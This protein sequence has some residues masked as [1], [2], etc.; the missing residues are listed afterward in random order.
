MRKIS[1]LIGLAL[2]C[3]FGNAQNP[4][5][6]VPDQYVTNPGGGNSTVLPLPVPELYCTGVPNIPDDPDSGYDGQLSDFS[7]N[8]QL[9][10]AGNILF[11]IVDGIIYD[12]NGY[13]I[14]RMSIYSGGPIAAGASETVIVPDPADCNRY[15]IIAARVQN[16]EKLAHVFLLDMSLPNRT[17][18]GDNCEYF[19]RLVELTCPNSNFPHINL[20]VSCVE[21]S[22]DPFDHS[23]GKNS[24]C[25]IAASKMQPGGH[26]FVFISN[27][28]G[29]FRFRID[30]TGFNYDNHF[31]SFGNGGMTQYSI[32][33][34]MELVELQGGGFRLAVPYKT[35]TLPFP[36]PNWENLFVVD[37][38]AN[39]DADPSTVIKFHMV[40][41]STPGG[42]DI[43][44]IIKGVEFSE[45]GDRIYV[46][47]TTNSTQPHQMEFYDFGTSPVELQPFSVDPNIDTRF[48]M[49]EL[50]K[51]DNMILANENGLY[52]LPNST[53]ANP[54][55]L[56]GLHMFNYA[57]SYE[58]NAGSTYRKMY[59][60]PDQ[61]DGMD[62]DAQ[63]TATVECCLNSS[64]FEADRFASHTDNW[65]GNQNPFFTS[66]IYIKEEFRVP[67]GTELTL[68][69]LSIHFA[70]GARLVIE[71]GSNGQQGGKLTLNN[72]VLTVDQRCT[73]DQMW[74]GV[75]VWGNTN[76]AQGSLNNSTQGR[77]IMNPSSRI[78]HAWIGALVS[79]RYAA[80]TSSPNGCPDDVNIYP[81]T[82]ED[83][84]N[85]GIVRAA[86]STFLNNQRGVWFRPYLASTGANNLSQFT[87]TT[88]RWDGPLKG[89]ASLQNQAQLYSVKGITFR[90]CNFQNTNPGAFA[91]TQLGTGILSLR[92]Q[93]YVLE[94]CN[95]ITQPCE[96]CPSGVPSTFDNLRFGIRTI[97]PGNMTFTV[98]DS[99]FNNC[100]YGMDV[101]L[102]KKGRILENQFNIR[103]ASYQ[104]AGVVLRYAPSFTVEENAFRGLGSSAGYLSY[105]VV[106]N[107]SG[108]ADNDIYLNS[109]IDLH[110]GGQSEYNN[111]VELTVAND[112]GNGVSMTGLNWTCNS[113]LDGIED[114]DL[115]V[116]NGRIDYFQ[117]HAIGHGSMNE[118]IRGSARNRFSLHGEPLS[119]EHDVVVS[120]S[121][122][123]EL[124]YVGLNTPFYF[125]DSYSSN[126]VL[127]LISS[128]NGVLA[129]ATPG[130]C[131]SNCQGDKKVLEAKRLQLQTNLSQLE[132]DW[133]DAGRAPVEEKLR[134][135]SQI[136]QTREQ[137]NLVDKQLLSE[138]LSSYESLADLE[139]ELSALDAQDL[140]T[141]LEAVFASDLSQGLP[142][143]E[144]DEVD[145]FLPIERTPARKNASNVL[146]DQAGF[147]VYPNPSNGR[148]AIEL[149]LDNP[150]GTDLQIIDLMGRT[151][152]QKSIS[153]ASN[154]IDLSD[155]SNGIYTLKLT[156]GKQLIGT[157]K[158]E[159]NR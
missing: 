16:Y 26:H 17:S 78:E 83:S 23:S 117:G 140:F 97:N 158:I 142:N 1:I 125:A 136:H 149:D 51:N 73:T 42:N 4:A 45:H 21:N 153:K 107:N 14:D 11:F 93:F 29:V 120:G 130:M 154:A 10:R 66:N 114:A 46:T 126:W 109:F 34:E 62:Y 134:I 48:S 47:H 112:P 155:L 56:N 95:V 118:A 60:L 124:Q 77:L 38:D 159:I 24:N 88:F 30:A 152:F 141:E 36:T 76:E 103:Q 90:G 13:F 63:F 15:Y 106:V 9:D 28:F 50:S 8:V 27:G 113:F 148:V 52:Q 129:T 19:G 108:V 37:L 33:S 110:V 144:F 99:E 127:P 87:R 150:E 3:L 57:P 143:E 145:A 91:Y 122:V 70:P 84:R 58:G 2:L 102:T 135:A 44:A 132:A 137:F 20:P 139:V 105:G 49:L 53:T 138:V 22:I 35:N 147:S 59:M 157:Q 101:R 40:R 115:A 156:Q 74:L 121:G 133:A 72:T 151:V 25:F 81:F 146:T 80:I 55:D 12:G 96:A 98:K 68:N 69:N 100:Q 41:L 111:A 64:T 82:F 119:D 5:W 43:S 131:P 94:N 71:N 79:K 54:T 75:E 123:Q 32:R 39:G 86:R 7:S 18:C 65:N 85:G 67:A 61:I 104:T 31:I 116:V 128:Y 6:A 89:G 92:A